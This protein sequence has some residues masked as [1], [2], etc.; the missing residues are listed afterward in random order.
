MDKSESIGSKAA[1][2]AVYV[3]I[4]QAVRLCLTTLST[5]VVSRI[6]LPG[7]YG[8]IAMVSPV[9]AFI[10]MFQDLG[11]SQATIQARE[12]TQGQNSSLFWINMG[13][14]AVLTLVLLAVSPLIGA[15]YGDARAGVVTAASAINIF[16]AGAS[17]Q[18]SA[19]LNRNMRFGRIALI[20]VANVASTFVATVIAAVLLRSYWAIWIGTLVGTIAT[21]VLLWNSTGFR[22]SFP[23]RFAGAGQMARF[24]GNVSGFNLV[25]FFSRNADNVLI[26]K[27]AGAVQLGL[28]DRSYKLMMLPLQNV[29]QPLGRVMLP[30]LRRVRD[31]AAAYRRAYLTAVRAMMLLTIPGI[32]VTVAT[33]NDLVAFLL[34]SKWVAAGPIFF[35]LSL[36]GLIQP[37]ANTTG[38]LFVS[39]GRVRQQLHW[40]VF[41]TVITLAGFAIGV[42]WGAVGV[43]ASLFI[44]AAL[45]IPLLYA[46]C[47]RDTSVAAAD[48]YRAM[49]EPLAGA[50]IT[51]AVIRL[52][53][54]F[55]P[56]G[57]LLFAG[58]LFSYA[59]TL[60]LLALTPAGRAFLRTVRRLLVGAVSSI[61][62]RLT[63]QRRT[64]VSQ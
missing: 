16:I 50:A 43:A 32:A 27:V 35:W 19:L 30:A 13:A 40:G 46:Y 49:V 44:T 9:T 60:A 37:L 10:L 24:G 56:F 58:L 29:N 7:D 25:N 33:S 45:R 17:L 52:G 54:A 51:V 8:V 64:Q 28:Y 20:D 14:S 12:I 31:D 61:S 1:S 34:G 38:W 63:R 62:G 2:S 36:T 23:P 6:L 4:S 3:G 26:A 41:S 48:L 22:P 47:T 59:I 18:H 21:S 42:R 39:S 11:L 5:I 15:F 57:P 55:L 53:Y